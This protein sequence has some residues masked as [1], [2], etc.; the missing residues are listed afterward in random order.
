ML[1]TE[2]AYSMLPNLYCELEKA[3][4]FYYIL[5]DPWI[6]MCKPRHCEERVLGIGCKVQIEFETLLICRL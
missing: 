3:E 4:N 1:R 2:L 6:M 5:H